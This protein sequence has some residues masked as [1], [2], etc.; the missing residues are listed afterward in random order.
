MTGRRAGLTAVGSVLALATVG[1]VAIPRHLWM[2]VDAVQS[3]VQDAARSGAGATRTELPDGRQLLIGG[4]DASR[5]AVIV[6][7]RTGALKPAGNALTFGRQWHT[8]TVLP[9]GTV[10]ILGGVDS[11]GQVVTVAEIFDPATTLFSPA[12]SLTLPAR[13]HHRTTVLSDGQVLVFGGRGTEPDV[14][15][16]TVLW[17]P[18]TDAVTPI[19]GGGVRLD[20]DVRTLADGRLH[21][22]GGTDA[23]GQR[24]GGSLLFEPGANR[25]VTVSA[26]PVESVDAIAIT[27]TWP[28]SEAT[29]V[30]PGVQLMA[31]FSSSIDPSSVTPETV[32]LR[33]PAAPVDVA[34]VSVEQGRLLFVSPRAALDANTT[35]SLTLTGLRDRRGNPVSPMAL[36][37][38]TAS[39]EQT[40]LDPATDDDWW[41]P[42]DHG[43]WRADRPES[44]WQKLP[45]LQAGAGESAVA[46]Q[47]LTLDGRPLAGVTLRVAGAS[48]QSDKSGRFLVLL[49]TAAT[50]WTRLE[51]EGK[52]ANRPNKTYGF[53]EARLAVTAGRTTVLPY[54]VWMPRLD[55]A[56]AV[57]IASPTTRETVI[58]TPYI[59]GLE[60]RLP[61]GTVIRDR[62]GSAVRTISITPI[63]VDRP[64]F[65]L[66][67]NVD[68]PVYF[69][70][71]PGGA[72]VYAARSSG[73]PGAQ[74]VYPNY[75]NEW[76]GKRIQF[77][78]YDPDERGWYVYGLG[79][80]TP[81]GKQVMP[82]A[83]TRLYEFTGAMLSTGD[84]PPPDAPPGGGGPRAGDPVD[85]STGLFIYEKT[86]LYVADVMPVA[87]TRTYRTNDLESRA[88]GIG[89]THPYEM[90]LWSAN[91]YSE[92][93]LILP[94]GAR[95]HYVRT[96][97]GVGYMDA[98]F[99][100]IE[101]ATTSATPTA[102]Y[103]SRIAWNGDG[104]NLRLR[105]GLTYVFG[106]NAPLREIRDRNGNTIRIVRSPGQPI[107]RVESPNGRWIAFTYS[108][109]RV[110]LA[111]DN[112]GRTVAYTYDASGRLW[113]VTDAASGVT[114][115]TY[116]TAH[117]MKTIK[118]PRNIVFLTNDYDANGRVILQTQAD[119]TTYEFAWTLG[120]TGNVTQV[121]VTNPRDIVDR[122]TFNADKYVMSLTEGVGTSLQ[123]TISLVRTAGSNFV[124]S[125][126]DPLN[127]V[128]TATYD[129]LGNTASVTRLS[130]TPEAVTAT[131]TWTPTF[132]QLA[133]VTDALQHTWTLGY[134]VK[135]NLTT[136]TDPLTHQMSATHDNSGLVLTITDALSQT[137]HF[138]YDQG[139][140]S[141]VTDPLGNRWS[142]F[143]DAAGRVLGA[144]D[145]MGRVSRRAVDTL[146]RP[147]KLSDPQGGDTVLTWDPNG[148]L[149]S[150]LDPRQSLTTWTYD[151]L[152]RV[153]TRTDPLQRGESYLYDANGN[154]R[155]FT[156]RKGQVSTIVYDSLDRVQTRTSQGGATLTY[157]FDGGDRLTQVVDSANGVI[158]RGYDSLDRLTTE[159]TPEGA[160]GATYDADNRRTTFTVSGQPTVSYTYDE[161]NRLTAITQGTS[162]VGF[163]HDSTDRRTSLSLPN[164]IVTEYVYD[165]ASRLTSLT[166]RLGAAPLGTLTYDYD[167]AGNR[168][169]VGGTWARTELP[170]GAIGSYDVAHQLAS[171]NGVRHHYDE[172]GNLIDDGERQF[173]WNARDELVAISGS[174]SG[175]FQYDGLGRRRAK[176][177]AGTTIG[178]LYDGLNA[179]QEQTAGVPSANIQ[180]G[181][182]LD[183]WY[184]R[185]DATGAKSILT[186]ALGS[187]VALADSGGIVTTGYAYE[188]FGRPTASGA[189]NGNP[190]EFTGREEDGT[191]L[192]FYRARA[193]DPSTQRFVSE[194]PLRFRGG[195][196]NLYSYLSNNPTG[197][198][199]PLGLYGMGVHYGETYAIAIQVGCSPDMAGAI[200]AG[201]Q[202]I[203]DSP[204][205]NPVNGGG[206]LGSHS[207]NVQARSDWH[208][209]TPNRRNKLWNDAMTG[210][211]PTAFGNYLHA[212][213]DSFSHQRGKTDRDGEPYSPVGGHVLPSVDFSEWGDAWDADNPRNRPD[214]WRKMI[215]Q[216]QL[217]IWA[218]CNSR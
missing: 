80:V 145:P 194:D 216:T 27:G 205:T 149:L 94:D 174:M 76:V 3:A 87:L 103:K 104:W 105:D 61:A 48:A 116:D 215:K 168:A 139:L 50:G 92:A 181:L 5:T 98:A 199:D 191:G 24:A 115:Y 39:D 37:F 218:Y 26:P 97:S 41:S 15:T 83:T 82:D 182:G 4:P 34:A 119:A 51:I 35:Y 146:N 175:G 120:P 144:T 130:G 70:I 60:L 212:M 79:T 123:R 151:S 204:L 186:D 23:T 86:D 106:E 111:K 25:F 213:Q 101:T 207:W 102:F 165:L 64:P 206:G 74:L 201:N 129:S 143:L 192:Y 161:A 217:E 19:E 59:P 138:T 18:R 185:N 141:A 46:G 89:A 154:P 128:T 22:S 121:Q 65:P 31:R 71:Q 53:F 63:P 164:G 85:L 188:P 172:N 203:D 167:P 124:T 91:Q 184:Q 14:V 196:V 209:T 126:T 158:V 147:T 100:H 66:A 1:A 38:T 166:Y 40:T 45:P 127:R 29:D 140:L 137:T 214:L 36:S 67:A 210:G 49:S 72:Y 7:P 109:G 88:F 16:P 57:A 178:F 110:T 113:K 135:G 56:H 9:D 125:M 136:I 159:T 95:I 155:Q 171:W 96:S 8:A 131:Y 47:V 180:S 176:T 28:L 107:S 99:E 93:D 75:R 122:Y 160:V 150:L 189:S 12:A 68:V 21:I 190:S 132:S 187:T 90:F 163:G 2:P 112:I 77:F 43:H 20:A 208:F 58:T 133:T 211:S 10:L 44:P 156:D 202:G 69:T 157:T 30:E 195:D 62:D 84:S 153:A 6:D 33:G 183:D 73:E 134:D 108:G 197:R 54:T 11:A 193:Y 198:R 13:S 81:N 114:E 142:R 173:A 170:Q 148:N 118:D 32:S 179:V 55:T 152:D 78:Q 117:R 42:K 17:D 200:A 177:V 162:I 169:G 52:T